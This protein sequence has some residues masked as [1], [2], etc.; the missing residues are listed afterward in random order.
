MENNRELIRSALRAFHAND[1]EALATLFDDNPVLSQ[2][3]PA[4]SNW[5]D[6][7]ARAGVDMLRLLVAKGCRCSGAAPL[8]TACNNSKIDCVEFLLDYGMDPNANRTFISAVNG[9]DHTKS[10]QI[11]KLLIQHGGDPNKCYPF[12]GR[13]GP[14]FN[15]LSWA[16][17]TGKKDIA[18]YLRSVGAKT[19][20]ELQQD[21]A[22]SLESDI[23]V[24]EVVD[25]EVIDAEVVEAEAVETGEVNSNSLQGT[26]YCDKVVSFFRQNYGPVQPL[27]MN[28]II[29]TGMPIAVHV[30]PASPG[31]DCVT[32]FTT[33][34]SE[35]PLSVPSGLESYRY[36]ELVIDLPADWPMDM[37]EMGRTGKAWP[38]LWLRNLARVP[39][40][41]ET[42]LYPLSM[43]STGEPP[44]PVS[45]NVPFNAFAL[46]A[47][48]EADIEGRTVQVFR[49]LPLFPEERALYLRE[50]GEALLMAL[51]RH[52]IG[53]VVTTERKNVA[54]S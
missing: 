18:E 6:R 3:K 50:G 45:Q 52:G 29:P 14:V 20:E 43:I 49:V 23:P 19:P 5:L 46:L 9:K 17:A 21:Q 38:F 24:A 39:H 44:E 41:N 48:K 11:V 53:T 47:E 2:L 32:L 36:T 42:W 8:C 51:D 1:L 16:E 13:D 35:Q 54:T 25:A 40:E 12:G 27:S 26:R 28:E 10:L 4:G 33:G 34:M 30:I 7:G 15:A 37:Q 31:R 22:G